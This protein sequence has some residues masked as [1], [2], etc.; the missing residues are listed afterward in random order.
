MIVIPAIDLK[1]GKCVRLRQGR[2]DSSTVF[3]EDPVNQAIMWQRL[4]AKRIHLV[5]LNG[6]VDGRPVNLSVVQDIVSA[7]NVPIELGGGVRDLQ[8]VEMY[9]DIGIRIVIIGTIAAKNPALAVELLR[10]FPGRVAIGIDA[11]AGRVA[12]E[13]WTESTGSDARELARLFDVHSPA[14]FIYTD[15]ER[16]GMMSGPNFAATAEFARAVNS[17]VILSGGVTTPDDVKKGLALEKEGVTGIIIGRALYEG[18]IDL[19]EAIAL[20]EGADVS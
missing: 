18:T 1:D 2:M 5:D 13:G 12:V 17:P 20:T 10:N 7:I 4:G 3:N 14:A 8:T 16:D 9:L 15:I 11:K 6:S 19:K